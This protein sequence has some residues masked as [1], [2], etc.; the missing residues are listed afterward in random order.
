MIGK[1]AESVQR[2]RYR[3]IS[4]LLGLSISSG[5]LIVAGT[6]PG[7]GQCGNC[8]ACVAGLPLLALAAV[9]LVKRVGLKRNELTGD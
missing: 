4:L 6:C 5:G 3:G 7:V 2:V 1:L 9:A 8:G